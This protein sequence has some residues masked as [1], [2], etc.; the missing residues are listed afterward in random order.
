MNVRC[1]SCETLFRVNPARVPESGVRARC[2]VCRSTFEVRRPGERPAVPALAS[3]LA[4]APA[5]QS[6]AGP[7][8]ERAGPTI[9]TDAPEPLAPPATDGG[10]EERG[11]WAS[12]SDMAPPALDAPPAGTVA[13]TGAD[14]DPA[15]PMPVGPAW[16]SSDP[17]PPASR[18]ASPP[19]PVA[20]EA[21]QAPVEPSAPERRATPAGP[22]VF[23]RSD[24]Q[25]RA[26]R[27]A[28]A[29]VSDIVAYHR[30]R[31]DRA[32]Q[33]GTLRTELREEI[34]KSWE[35]YVE[36]VGEELAKSTPYFRDALNAILAEGKRVF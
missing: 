19:A 24:P 4:T 30:D 15:P 5:A 26:R 10:V 14:Q 22:R 25:T 27:I 32:L 7:P 33:R 28:R 35:E 6:T 31:R 11:G 36:Q 16:T 20:R 29:L 13:G 2:S 3:G 8:V 34:L 9:G 23:G 12:A 17:A 21:A 1:P 18:D